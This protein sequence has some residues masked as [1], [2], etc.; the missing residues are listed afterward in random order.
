MS[1]HEGQAS[2]QNPDLAEALTEH[3][4]DAICDLMDQEQ[5][6]QLIAT[7]AAAATL[8]FLQR[9]QFETAEALRQI[10]ILHRQCFSYHRE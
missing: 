3:V 2:K 5:G 4:C 9:H 7:R 10:E 6:P 1:E 8:E